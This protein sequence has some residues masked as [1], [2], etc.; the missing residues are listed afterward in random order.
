MFDRLL[1]L[2][3]FANIPVTLIAYIGGALWPKTWLANQ[4]VSVN[5]Q[6]TLTIAVL[7]LG[8]F[9]LTLQYF[10]LQRLKPASNVAATPGATRNDVQSTAPEGG[11]GIDLE[12]FRRLLPV[13]E[14]RYIGHEHPAAG[15]P[16]PDTWLQDEV[17]RDLEIELWRQL[18]DEGEIDAMNLP[19]SRDT[20]KIENIQELFEYQR[21]L[22]GAWTQTE[23]VFQQSDGNDR[24]AFEYMVQ[25]PTGG[26]I[27]RAFTRNPEHRPDP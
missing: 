16:L 6:I 22:R 27:H 10:S 18:F 11:H 14:R 13:L 4:G 1:K 23:R 17:G 9:A 3:D 15:R 25:L 12:V 5:W 2:G 24:H 21:L 20:Q 19:F 8:L 26:W 7:L